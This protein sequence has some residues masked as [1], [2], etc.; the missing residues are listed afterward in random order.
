MANRHC[1][2]L[3]IALALI[4]LAAPAVAAPA[5]SLFAA[6]DPIRIAIKGP[7][8]AAARSAPGKGRPATLTVA[9]SESHSILLSPRGITRRLSEICTF[10]PLR[11]EFAAKPA[12]ASLFAGQKRLKLV[13]HCH[14]DASFQ[15]HV[16]LE[17][18]AYRLFNALT[19]A[20]FR[21][22]L[23]AIDYAEAD[24]R[25]LI[26][27]YGFFIE[28][29]DHVARRNGLR[30]AKTGDAVAALALSPRD[31]ARYALFQYMIGNLDWSMR[32]G[33]AG[34][35]CCH[36]SRLIGP[37]TGPASA[38]IPVPYD[39]DMSGLVNAPYAVPPEGIPVESVRQRRYRGLCQHN[40]EALSVANEFRVRRGD[41]L[42]ALAEIPQL[43]E[44]TRRSAAAYL[45]DFFAD[46]AD[47]GSVARLLRTCVRLN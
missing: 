43:E 44:R 17:Y 6:S 24:G 20:S 37:G 23:V 31:A 39:F 5:A 12:A 45:Q 22:R 8:G 42:R 2:G 47:D 38:L 29:V 33:P 26:S 3:A 1:G 18:A 19:P 36:N 46:I 13:T 28:D 16:L 40:G 9:G 41:L 27:R 35:G 30:E 4:C 10:P 32:A 15:Q 7:I 34:R 14:R 25:P 11:V 21:A